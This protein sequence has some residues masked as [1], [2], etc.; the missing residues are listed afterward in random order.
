MFTR[1]LRSRLNIVPVPIAWSYLSWAFGVAEKD[2]RSWGKNFLEDGELWEVSLELLNK[3]SIGSSEEW[4]SREMM[5]EEFEDV[6]SD[7]VDIEPT[8][9]PS[10]KRE[11]SCGQ[12]NFSRR[13]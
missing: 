4:V 8:P 3:E 1:R 2:K 6:V 13:F 10:R 7:G 11:C 5:F 9:Q 12:L